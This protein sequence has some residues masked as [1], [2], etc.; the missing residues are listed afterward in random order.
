[1]VRTRRSRRSRRRPRSKIRS[2][3][4]RRTSRRVSRKR[5]R[6]RKSYKKRRQRGGNLSPEEC[7]SGMAVKNLKTKETGKIVS[8]ESNW[9]RVEKESDGNK[10]WWSIKELTKASP[11]AQKAEAAVAEESERKKAEAAD[12]GI[13]QKMVERLEWL[14]RRHQLGLRDEPGQQVWV[15]DSLINGTHVIVK[16]KR[17]EGF[18]DHS[19]Q[20]GGVLLPAAGGRV[21]VRLADGDTKWYQ[22]EELAYPA[23]EKAVE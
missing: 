4:R 23:K 6:R 21:R 8:R 20:L 5:G 7:V 17:D 15:G 16:E 12:K 19:A 1:M 22:P 2:Q 13:D 3:G 14:Q 9:V 18:V 11:E 10:V